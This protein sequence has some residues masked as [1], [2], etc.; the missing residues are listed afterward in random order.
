[1]SEIK[2]GVC[3]F[4]LPCEGPA[5]FQLA[6]Q[7]GFTGIQLG[8][9]GGSENGYPFR[10]PF[11][12]T[13]YKEASLEYGV[14]LQAMHLHTLFRQR[15]IDHAPETPQG[16]EARAAVRVAAEACEA[17]GIPVMM[18]TVT[19]I[20]SA[21]QYDNVCACL[22]YACKL[23]E[24]H[25]LRLAVETDLPPE[26]FSAM[27]RRVGDIFLC[28]DTM[29][30]T[31]YGIGQP[32]ALIHAYGMDLIDHFHVKDCCR[33]SRGYFT[34]YTTPYRLI[35]QGESGFEDCARVIEASGYTGWLIS[36]TFYCDKSFSGTFLSLAS[37]DAN[38][39]RSRFHVEP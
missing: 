22:S 19:N 18:I 30:P 7:A 27:R 25:G 24:D 8:D 39:L 12:R 20:Y 38:F 9:C 1:M 11:I 17:M 26:R 16:E 14:E 29:N 35:G 21:E 6:Q 3:E 15:F 36:E 2:L 33:N 4:C 5:A 37:A 31:V 34:K 23:C 13:S 10:D 32:A 28:F